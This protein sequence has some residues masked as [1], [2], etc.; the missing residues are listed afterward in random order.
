MTDKSQ[1]PRFGVILLALIFLLY[2]VLISGSGITILREWSAISLGLAVCGA[3]WTLCGPAMALG[4]L[5]LLASLGRSFR[6]LR[7]GG[8]GT[9]IAGFVMLSAEL[10]HVLPC[11]GA[12]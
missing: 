9:A 3:M 4:A 6:A 10:I 5:W 1:K 12:A 8:S 2:S 7:I 11:T